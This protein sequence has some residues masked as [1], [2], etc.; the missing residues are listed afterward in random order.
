MLMNTLNENNDHL[1]LN[2]STLHLATKYLLTG[3]YLEFF[4]ST[5]TGSLVSKWRKGWCCY[6]PHQNVL[7]WWQLDAITGRQATLP[8]A[9]SLDCIQDVDLSR[10]IIQITLKKKKKKKKSGKDKNKKNNTVLLKA[11]NEKDARAWFEALLC[12]VLHRNQEQN[13]P[14]HSSIREHNLETKDSLYKKK[15]IQSLTSITPTNTNNDSNQNNNSSSSQRKKTTDSILR[16]STSFAVSQ[17]KRVVNLH[18]CSQCYSSTKHSIVLTLTD[19]NSIYQKKRIEKIQI[20]LIQ[21]YSQR[22]P[23]R[24]ECLEMVDVAIKETPS[25]NLIDI[26]RGGGGSTGKR[27]V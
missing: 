11:E 19:I 2:N 1:N 23:N 20:Q 8:V 3:G 10:L 13:T 26:T 25:F 21:K 7:L 15:T 12:L 24:Y 14:L 6:L 27:D 5:G 4:L 18:R 22:L 17:T 9:T 16:R